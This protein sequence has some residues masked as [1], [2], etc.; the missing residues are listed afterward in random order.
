VIAHGTV[1]E[2]ARRAAAPRTARLRVASDDAGLAAAVLHQVPDIREVATVDAEPGLLVLGL[3]PAHNGNEPALNEVV[4]A[5][6][7]SRVTVV[8]FELEGAR[9][10]DAFLAMTGAA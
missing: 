3:A 4:S 2:V 6:I 1:A 10:S 8:S 7:R 9:L 5:L